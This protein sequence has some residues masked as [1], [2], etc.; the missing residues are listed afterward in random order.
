MVCLYITLSRS[1]AKRLVWPTIREINRQYGLGGK[2]NITELSIT[3]PNGSVIYLSGASTE[4]EIEKFRGLP[5]K[6]VYIDEC[7]SFREYIRELVDD[8][9]APALMDFAGHLALIGTPSAVPTGYFHD[10]S[11]SDSWSHHAWNFF[12]NP[13][14]A[15]K[16]KMTHQAILERELK[17]RGVNLA[18]PSIQREWCGKWVLDSDS[19]L[20]HYSAPLNDY[21][22][23][24]PG[25]MTYIMGVDLGFLDSD[26]IAVIAFCDNSPTTWLVE[27]LVC[28]KQDISNLAEQIETLRSK[29]DISKI[30]IDTGGLGKKISEELIRRHRI[31]ME[32][33]DKVRKMENVALLN[34]ALRSGRFKAPRSSRFAQDCF[35]VEIDREKSTPDRIAVS[36]RYHSDIIDAVLYAFKLSPA[37][38]Y[39][40]PA[41]KPVEG[42]KAWYDA[43]AERLEAAAEEYFKAKWDEEHR[44]DPFDY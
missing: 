23:V 34:D 18:D 28:P 1:T 22:E 24:Q 25:K 35:L 42:T 19:L 14:I 7:Q 43:E 2:E 26:A 40:P 3:F 33:A 10:C 11:N 31:P 20:L 16:S 8:V 44:G 37:Y 30:V 15:S 38:T 9:I 4:A 29:Y 5:L 21:E 36:T 13:F 12:D 17:R 27:E 6:L 41:P 32:P 39:E